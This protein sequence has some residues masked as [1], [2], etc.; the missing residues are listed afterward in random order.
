MARSSLVF[1]RQRSPLTPLY[2]LRLVYWL[3]V[4]STEIAYSLARFLF[5]R[6]LPYCYFSNVQNSTTYMSMS[7]HRAYPTLPASVRFFVKMRFSSICSRLLLQVDLLRR[8]CWLVCRTLKAFRHQWVCHVSSQPA[9]IGRASTGA[10]GD[11]G[12]GSGFC[13][14]RHC[15]RVSL[16]LAISRYHYKQRGYRHLVSSRLLLSA[17]ERRLLCW[18][19]CYLAALVKY[20]TR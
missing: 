14:C 17:L 3:P 18:L 8:F 16:T 15:N 11:S 2:K 1:S 10:A 4:L 7:C 9:V 19:A 12:S 6:H 20:V 13:V 5:F